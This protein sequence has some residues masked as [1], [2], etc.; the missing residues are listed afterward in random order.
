M[1]E[2]S[3]RGSRGGRGGTP[4]N[5]FK[6]NNRNG[7]Y[8]VKNNP[9]N[10]VVHPVSRPTIDYLDEDTVISA[11]QFMAISFVSLG[12]SQKTDIIKRISE[13]LRVGNDLV[14]K[15]VDSWIAQEHPKRALKVRGCFP[16]LQA[17]RDRCEYLQKIDPEIATAVASVGKWVPYDPN[18]DLIDDQ[19]YDDSQLQEL[20][21]GYKENSI[22]SRQHYEERKR[23]MM[24]KAIQEGSAE[25]QAAAAAKEEPLV[26]VENRL[27]VTTETIKDLEERLSEARETLEKTKAKLDSLPTEGVHPTENGTAVAKPEDPRYTLPETAQE[28]VVNY[29]RPKEDPQKKHAVRN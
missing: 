28:I 5:K 23:M 15:I 29:N 8:S 14:T 21:K 17:A 20:M 18:P 22:K 1:A 6:Y 4:R 13:G 7:R 26:A 19:V 27:K 24:E 25:G 9:A 12:D 16:D 10:A 3:T 2:N 11:Q